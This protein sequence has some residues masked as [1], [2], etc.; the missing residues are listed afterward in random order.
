VYPIM[1]EG[2]DQMVSAIW[3]LLA[4]GGHRM[5][6]PRA[7]RLAQG[8]GWFWRA[9]GIQSLLFRPWGGAVADR[10][11]L[12]KL[13]VVT[14]TLYCLLAALLW[15]LAA[16][17]KASVAALAAIGVAGGVVQIADSPARQA[18]V[19]R[20]VGLLLCHDVLDHLAAP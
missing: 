17:G 13:L 8:S 16:V 3:K 11:D 12:H 20:L 6:R 15:G 7:H 5:A 14:Q 19:S 10:V 9:G 1:R 2:T 18:F 4:A